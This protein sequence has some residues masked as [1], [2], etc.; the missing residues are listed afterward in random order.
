[1]LPPIATPLCNHLNTKQLFVALDRKL[2]PV[3]RSKQIANGHL[4]RVDSALAHVHQVIWRT[5]G[6]QRNLAEQRNHQ[7][8]SRHHWRAR[9]WN[10]QGERF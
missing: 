3:D 10:I 9:H 1:M 5:S 6:V 7:D 2:R 4:G 8:Q